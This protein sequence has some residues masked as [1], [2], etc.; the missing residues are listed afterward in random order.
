VHLDLDHPRVLVHEEDAL[1]GEAAVGGPVETALVVRTPQAAEGA[2]VDDVGVLGVHD[3]GADLEGLAEPG[4]AP[5][6]AAVLRHVDPVT[7]GDGVA[8]VVLTGAGPDAVG[9]GGRD[10]K[11]TH[12]RRPLVGE[13]V[14]VGDPIVRGVEH[15]AGRRGDPVLGGVVGIHRDVRDAPAHVGRTDGAPLEGVDP[16]EGELALDL[17]GA[18]LRELPLRL[19]GL[20]R[21]FGLFCGGLSCG[22]LFL[23][24]RRAG[25]GRGDE[26][27]GQGCCAG[28]KEESLRAREG[29]DV[30]GDGGE[31]HVWEGWR[32]HGAWHRASR[33]ITVLR[34]CWRSG[35]VAC[36]QIEAPAGGQLRSGACA[37][38]C[39]SGSR[40]NPGC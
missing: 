5:G 8:R 36:D 17:G 28:P 15:S 35:S 29:T 22:G 21:G 27:S 7:P 12:G 14:L 3:D 9:I 2:H 39:P 23:G 11:R 24:R 6:R 20:R 13:Q 32:G 34:R 10:G 16:V 18:T 26:R 31:H 37:A 40:A 4:V 38:N 25:E 30:E 19:L 33:T 1:P